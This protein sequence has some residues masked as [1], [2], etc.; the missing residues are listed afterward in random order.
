MK[1][2]NKYSVHIKSTAKEEV[3]VFIREIKRAE[4]LIDIPSFSSEKID[5]ISFTPPELVHKKGNIVV[6]KEEDEEE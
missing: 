4:K 5:Y 6:A 3:K 2:G 1:H